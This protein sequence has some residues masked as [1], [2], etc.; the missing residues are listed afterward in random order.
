MKIVHFT[1]VVFVRSFVMSFFFVK[2]Y[3]VYEWADFFLYAKDFMCSCILFSLILARE[4]HR[5]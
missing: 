4:P 3:F 2:V 5:S 1:Q